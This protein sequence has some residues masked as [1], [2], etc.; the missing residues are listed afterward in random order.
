M[1]YLRGISKKVLAL[2]LPLD[3]ISLTQK[4]TQ[5]NSFYGTH[6]Q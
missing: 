2:S 3:K 1:I 6:I 5:P 4:P